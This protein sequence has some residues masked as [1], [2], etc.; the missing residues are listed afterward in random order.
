MKEYSPKPDLWSKIQLQKDFDSQVKAHAAN[1]SEKM[2]KTDLWSAI[3][4]QLDQKTPVVPLWKYGMVAASIGLILAL[5]GIVYLQ[6]GEKDVK[7]LLITEVNIPSTE[8]ETREEKPTAESESVLIATEEIKPEKLKTNASPKQPANRE[9]IVPIAL[10][11]LDLARRTIEDKVLSEL[12]I[13]STPQLEELQTLHKV[14]ISW[15]FQDK[16]KLQT[17]FAPH[18]PEII[19]IQ[20]IGRAE[21]PK[22]SIKIY[23][24]KQ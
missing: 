22:K 16:K 5:S 1:L 9:T 19:A 23:F 10:P 6:F 3:E 15:G 13:P 4:N 11:K 8:L 17:T 21:Q 18:T 7:P 12:K 2:P 14:H 20:Q 24:Q